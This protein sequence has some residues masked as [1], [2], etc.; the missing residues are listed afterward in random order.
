MAAALWESPSLV[1]SNLVCALLR[2]FEFFCAL[3]RTCVCIILRSF[4]FFCAHLH[5]SA[6][7]RA[8]LRTADNVGVR[9]EVSGNP[10]TKKK[11]WTPH[12]KAKSTKETLR[13]NASW[14]FSAPAIFNPSQVTLLGFGKIRVHQAISLAIASKLLGKS[15]GGLTNGGLSPKFSE[16]IGGKSFLENRAFSG[17]IGPISGLVGAF[18]GPIGTNSSAPHSRGGG[19]N[20]PERALFGPIGPFRAKPP[21]A[22][23][24]FGFPRNYVAKRPFA[25]N[26]HNED[27]FFCDF[28]RKAIRIR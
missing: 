6:S 27:D 16:K 24:P 26:F 28:A 17:Q 18:S 22:K 21:F 11:T 1:V 5:V 3:L 9:L 23:P 14:F 7:D 4:A 10:L 15:K 20:S 13:C 8:C 19:R 25:K 12:P 2:P